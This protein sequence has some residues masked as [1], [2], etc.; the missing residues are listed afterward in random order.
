MT[1]CE[2]MLYLER[3]KLNRLV[4]EALRNGTP[5]S[6]PYEIMDQRRKVK[7]MAG[8]TKKVLQSSAVQTQ[9]R[10]VDDLVMQMER[11]RGREMR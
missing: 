2:R 10:K 3:E 6:E 1:D 8:E 11:E 9:S 5:L 4:D 7:R